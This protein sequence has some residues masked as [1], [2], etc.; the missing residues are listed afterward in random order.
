MTFTSLRRRLALVCASA[1]VLIAPLVA[2]PQQAAGAPTTLG[3]AAESP[4][5]VPFIGSYEVWCTVRNPAPGNRCSQ[6][7]GSPAIDLGMDPGTPVYAAGSGVVIETE[8]GCGP[9]Y[10]RGGAGNFISI[11]HADGTFSRYLHLTDVTVV[12]DDLVEVGQQ[13]GTSGISGQS[14]SAHLHYDEHF[15]AGTRT[16]MGSWVGCVDGEQVHYPEAFGVSDW[17]DV[18]YGSVVAND[19][20]EC[21]EGLDLSHIARPV[22]LSGDESFGVVAPTQSSST[23]FQFS[24]DYQ[25]DA[26]PVIRSLRG[27]ALSTLDA[28]DAP[29][30]IRIREQADG[31]WQAWSD[32]VAYDPASVPSAPTC[33]GLH[34]TTTETTGTPGVD[35]MIG[36]DGDDVLDGRGGDDRI[37]GGDGNDSI[38]AGP[39][40]DIVWGGAGDD[41]IR[42]GRGADEILAGDGDDIVRG[43]D[44]PDRV[45]GGLGDD[46]LHGT[47]GNDHVVGGSGSD[48][49]VGGIGHDQLLGGPDGDTLEGRNGRDYV[50]GGK[51]DDSLSGGNGRDRLVGAAGVDTFDG[52]T[53]DD[54]CAPDVTAITEIFQG[55][56]R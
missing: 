7:H 27:R 36:T 41:E 8:T 3:T 4:I 30:A 33:G 14:S 22:I 31:R 50:G 38:K 55:C 34:A 18:P 28:P 24:V 19:G 26:P 32:P 46:E 6:H 23:V 56:E 21:L 1:L 52:G 16:P 37:C 10:C 51:G 44:G 49:V 29:V 43:G 17:V 11:G 35:V 54:R 42:G 48:L 20:F 25:D 9:G 39:G 2:Q 15:P 45:I 47:A 5:A 53:G 40:R 13:I 12:A